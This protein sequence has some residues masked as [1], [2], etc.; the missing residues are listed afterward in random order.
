MGTRCPASPKGSRGPLNLTLDTIFPLPMGSLPEIRSKAFQQAAL[1]SERVRVIG[2]LVTLALLLLIVVGRALVVSS[3]VEIQYLPIAI[4]LVGA[5]MAH[6]GAMLAVVNR[7][8]AAQGDLPAWWWKANLF[9][10]TLFPT[11]A[12]LWLTESPVLGPYR[13]L[14][15][16]AIL[17]YFFFILLSTLRL[18]PS[19]RAGRGSFL[20]PAIWQWR[21]TLL[22]ATL[23]PIGCS[24]LGFFGPMGSSSCWEG[25]WA[26]RWLGNPQ[27]RDRL[28]AGS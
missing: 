28:P 11:L 8:I 24:H 5:M 6:E 1:R 23:L 27:T 25:L 20:A 10:E 21:H 18:N 4:V 13:A 15:A 26:A 3:G 2:V 14:V 16:P 19:R 9:A 7:Q 12:L 17:T 22:C